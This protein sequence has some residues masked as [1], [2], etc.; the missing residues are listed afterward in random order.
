MDLIVELIAAVVIGLMELLI[1]LLAL[2]SSVMLFVVELLVYGVAGAMERFQERRRTLAARSSRPDNEPG[3]EEAT[4]RSTEAGHL[5]KMVVLF[6][7]VALVIGAS[8]TT[9][10]WTERRR[11]AA[12][13]EQVENLADGFAARLKK[14]ENV[15]LRVGQL[16]ERDSW[17]RP[18]KLRIDDLV[19]GELIVVR[20]T[21]RDGAG[22]TLDDLLATRVVGT[23]VREVGGNAFRRMIEAAGKKLGKEHEGD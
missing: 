23:S 5:G 3:V 19:L 2:V 8:L 7:V 13:R 17:G 4:G 20:S 1:R 16:V 15:A 11:E 18:L 12:T 22:G 21:G 14:E 6:G 10:K 9:W